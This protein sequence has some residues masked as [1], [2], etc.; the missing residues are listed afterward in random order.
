MDK[1]S[2]VDTFRSSTLLIKIAEPIPRIFLRLPLCSLP[3]GAR[4]EMRNTTQLF[5]QP[6][7]VL[8]R[9]TRHDNFQSHI[10]VPT[11]PTTFIETLPTQAKPLPALRASGNVHLDLSVNRG[12][13]QPRSQ[14]RFPGRN[15]QLYF[16]IIAP[17]REY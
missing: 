9:L 6:P 2:S 11:T 12:H 7:F 10:F 1:L 5:I 3:T 17:H 14:R 4:V 15:R 13:F 8:A 16:K